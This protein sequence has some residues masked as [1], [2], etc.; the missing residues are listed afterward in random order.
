[1]KHKYIAEISRSLQIEADAISACLEI[2][3]KRLPFPE[4]EIL[5]YFCRLARLGK[6]V[7]SEGRLE[8]RIS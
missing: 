4:L 7:F 3:I 8:R 1:M 6:L 5:R 2:E